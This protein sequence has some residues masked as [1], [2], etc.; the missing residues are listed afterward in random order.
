MANRVSPPL[1]SVQSSK[2]VASPVDAIFSRAS[3]EFL[4]KSSRIS[5]AVVGFGD[6]HC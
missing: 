5:A 4:S 1:L 3:A 2:K 6:S